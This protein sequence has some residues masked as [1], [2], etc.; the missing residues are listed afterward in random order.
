[1]VYERTNIAPNGEGWNGRV[2]GVI[3]SS[4]VYIYTAEVLCDNDVPFTYKGNVTLIR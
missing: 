4:D 3:A 1:M 2:R